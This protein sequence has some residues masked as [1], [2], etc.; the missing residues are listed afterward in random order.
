MN[1]QA[2]TPHFQLIDT[3][4]N[5]FKNI[6]NGCSI[7]LKEATAVIKHV[8]P[9][10]LAWLWQKYVL[11]EIKTTSLLLTAEKI[12]KIA[13]LNF[14]GDRSLVIHDKEAYPVLF[15]HGDHGY[16]F[17]LLHLAE[18]AK[19]SGHPTY[20]LYIPGVDNND[21]FEVHSQLLEQAIQKIEKMTA[22]AGGKFAGI[23]GVGH[24]K[25]AILLAHRQFAVLDTRI[26][27]ICSIAGRL[28]VPND[29]DCSDSVLTSKVRT[30]YQGILNHPELHLTQ[31]IPVDDW[32]ASFESMAV[33]PLE[34]CYTVPGMH[35]SGLYTPEACEHVT[36]FLAGNHLSSAVK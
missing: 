24:S 26:V 33:R 15:C 14:H 34:N 29:A 3:H 27:S 28:N 17:S 4:T 9:A 35:L 1:I 36:H 12:T 32:N 8:L 10:S 31:I 23:L 25:G 5:I 22:D 6:A 7:V 11:K 19:K 21:L 16:P 30:I 2:E 18:I 13:D 20:S